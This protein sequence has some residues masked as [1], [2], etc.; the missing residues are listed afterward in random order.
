MANFEDGSYSSQHVPGLI[1]KV[2]AGRCKMKYTRAAVG[3]GFLEEGESPKTMDG[4]A[5]YVMDAVIAAVTNPVDGECMV[6]VQVNSSGVE[7]GFFCTSVVL[8]AEDPDLGEV[9]YTYLF[10]ENGPEWIRPASAVVGKLATFDLIAAV[11]SVDAVEAVINP[12]AIM[13]VAAAQQ[14]ISEHDSSSNAHAAQLAQFLASHNADLNAHPGLMERVTTIINQSIAVMQSGSVLLRDITIAAED[15]EELEEPVDGCAWGVS[16]AV[17][18]ATE[19]HVPLVFLSR[20]SLNV[21]KLAGLDT[22]PETGEGVVQFLAKNKPEGSLACTVVLL[23]QKSAGTAGGGGT[24]VLPVATESTL[25]GI[26]AS[27]S[28]TVDADGVAHA[29][30]ELSPESFA[31]DEEVNAALDDIFGEPSQDDAP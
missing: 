20:E 3:S 13:T 19:E 4:P 22:V 2:L 21:A 17:E 27:D 5:G 28:V 16:A 29:Y 24:Y 14:M 26:R 23:S 1:G 30:A 9:P 25:G 6:T 18:D 15:W 8:Y 10:L 12:E 31:T 11:G 7:T